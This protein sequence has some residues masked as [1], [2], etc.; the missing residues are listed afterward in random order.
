MRMCEI[1]YW[2]NENKEKKRLY[3]ECM[4]MTRNV[5]LAQQSLARAIT[6]AVDE[7]VL[8]SYLCP[9]GNLMPRRGAGSAI[10][11]WR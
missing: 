3:S 5:D 4:I 11:S 7:A 9:G 6:L 8:E 10:D 2:P 1:M